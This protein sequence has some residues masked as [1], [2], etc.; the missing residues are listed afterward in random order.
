MNPMLLGAG[1]QAGG[2]LVSSA[3]QAGSQRR[4]NRTNMAYNSIQ[5]DANRRWQEQMSN[6]AY[7]RSSA[8][9]KAAGLNPLM[10]YGGGSAASQPSGAQSQAGA[11]GSDFGGITQGTT[12]AINSAFDARRTKQLER[13]TDSNIAMQSASAIAAIA[14]A[15]DK[16]MDSDIKRILLPGHKSGNKLKVATDEIDYKMREFD[17]IQRRLEG[18]IYSAKSVHMGTKLATEFGKRVRK[19]IKSIPTPSI[20]TK[21]PKYKKHKH[22]YNTQQYK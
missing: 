14:A 12:A 19:G 20:K 13:Q 5:A 2:G 18:T 7:Q 3:F 1:I 9:M 4:A 22:K 15:K 16:N 8:D 6:T 11:Q 17:R 21:L 10:M